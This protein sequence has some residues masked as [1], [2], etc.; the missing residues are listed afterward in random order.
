MTAMSGP[1][2]RF[3]RSV[4][5]PQAGQVALYRFYDAHEHLLYIGISNDPRRRWKQHAKSKPWYPQVRHQALTW[6]A[7]EAAARKAETIAI[8]QESPQYNIAGAIRPARARVTLPAHLGRPVLL[9][10]SGAL[11]SLTQLRAAEPGVR[12]ALGPAADVIFLALTAVLV[13][14]LIVSMAPRIRRFGAWVERNSS[15]A[16]PGCEATR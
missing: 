16:S 8:R 5:S 13:M 9:V 14:T 1:E 11:L 10:G 2:T 6:Y 4:A 7:S 12:T 15:H 3:P